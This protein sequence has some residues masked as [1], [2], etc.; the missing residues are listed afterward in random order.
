MT[1]FVETDPIQKEG[2]KKVDIGTKNAVNWTFYVTYLVLHLH[3]R[4]IYL[5]KFNILLYSLKSC[6]F[7]LPLFQI[8]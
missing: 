8:I 1:I 5:R 7:G 6:L 4:V 3:Q 2:R